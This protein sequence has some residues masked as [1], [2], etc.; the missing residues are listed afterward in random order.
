MLKEREAQGKP[1]P[2]QPRQ[3]VRQPP[4]FGLRAENL[5]D[6]LIAPAR[7]ESEGAGPPPRVEFTFP[8]SNSIETSAK[9]IAVVGTAERMNTRPNPGPKNSLYLLCRRM[10]PAHTKPRSPA[11]PPRQTGIRRRRTT[12][13][14]RVHIPEE[15]QHRNKCE[16]Y[17]SRR[18]S[19]EN[20]YSAEP[21][22]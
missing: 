1:G 8:R 15:Q 4:G 21:R 14:S 12:P 18:H 7:A 3:E 16:D 6:L 11:H 17:R 22:P 2:I 5:A 13:E 20:E 9:T 19:R 10:R